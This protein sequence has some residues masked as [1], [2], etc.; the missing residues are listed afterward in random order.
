MK[1]VKLPLIAL[2]AA[3]M[4]VLSACATGGT[5]GDTGGTAEETSTPEPEPTFAEGSTMAALAEAGS[6]TIGTKFD[7]PLFGLNG[8]NGPE[9]FDVEIG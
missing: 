5:G 4:L 9:G 2:A 6:I 7:Q 1:R 3:S 8:P